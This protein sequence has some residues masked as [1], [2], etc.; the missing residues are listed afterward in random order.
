MAGML[1][2][3]EIEALRQL[4]PD[5]G[6]NPHFNATRSLDS[7]Q[8]MMPPSSPQA[9]PDVA[10]PYNRRADSYRQQAGDLEAQKAATYPEPEGAKQ[11]LVSA[12]RAGMESFGRYGA[13][14]GYEGQEAAR[15][16]TFRDQQNKETDSRLDRAKQL[17]TQAQ[18]QQEMGQTATSNK[19]LNDYRTKEVGISQGNLDVN[20]TTEDRLQKLSNRP[21][22]DNNAPGTSSFARN[23]DTGMP[24][25]GSTV[26]TPAKPPTEKAWH[27]TNLSVE[28]KKEVWAVDPESGLPHHK[29]GDAFIDPNSGGGSDGMQIVQGKLGPDGQPSY[30]R[31][32]KKGP[33]GEIKIGGETLGT[34][35]AEAPTQLKNQGDAAYTTTKMATIVR[36]LV[37]TKPQLVGPA[38]GRIND[39][40][41]KVG[42]DPGGILSLASGLPAGDEK[43]TALLAGHLAYLFLNEA[44]ATMPGRPAAQ[45][46]DYVKSKSAQMSQ[47]PQI[48]EGFLQ[49]AENNAQIMMGLSEQAGYAPWK[50]GAAA[51]ARATP[52]APAG[53]IEIHYDVNGRR[54]K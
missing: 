19:E 39:L 48:I 4:L 1:T 30:V 21:V 35:P 24:I 46:M 23:A 26:T 7:P 13:P 37:K 54:I 2:P 38:V 49:S 47:N 45:Y 28:G 41:L 16:K 14:G 22:I 51:P 15:Q 34:K 6:I 27:Y 8:P 50:N 36:N 29:V 44:R 25:E 20:R 40:M 12:L 42:G 33:E 43:D 52:A 11:K 10:D 18:Q 53:G 17:R 5:S 9:A 32:N 31:V 3:E